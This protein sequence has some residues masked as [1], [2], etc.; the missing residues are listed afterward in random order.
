[1]NVLGT[2]TTVVPPYLKCVKMQKVVLTVFARMA[3]TAMKMKAV[4]VCNVVT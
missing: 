4:L 1:M 2:S 3:T